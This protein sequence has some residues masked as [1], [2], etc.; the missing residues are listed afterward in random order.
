MSCYHPHIQTHICYSMM[1]SDPCLVNQDLSQMLLH[2]AD[3]TSVDVGRVV[4][5]LIPSHK[6]VNLVGR[7]TTK[8]DQ[9]K[10]TFCWLFR[11][12]SK[13]KSQS[14]SNDINHNNIHGLLS[15]YLLLILYRVHPENYVPR[16]CFAGLCCDLVQVHFHHISQ[17]LLHCLWAIMQLPQCQENN[18]EEYPHK[19][20][21][22]LCTADNQN[23]QKHVHVSWAVLYIKA[24]SAEA[25]LSGRDK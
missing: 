3:I 11:W 22:E 17:G 7:W 12:K 25:G 20:C 5:E 14:N 24:L 18:Q 10:V 6:Q 9:I 16:C 21:K 13:T 8:C 23:Q 4:P 1:F 2:I 15:K 19:Y